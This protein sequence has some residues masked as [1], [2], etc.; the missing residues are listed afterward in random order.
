MF[1]FIYRW[2]KIYELNNDAKN[3]VMRTSLVH[4]L[5][6]FF[7]SFSN[8]YIFLQA[9]TVIGDVGKV[10]LL[11]SVFLFSEA[12]FALVAGTL[13]D[14][15]SFR[16]VLSLSVL[17]YFVTYRLV[18]VA[19]TFDQ[20]VL[21]YVLLGLSSAFNLEN[22]F[23]YFDNNYDYFV[24]EDTDR[25]IYSEFIGKFVAIKYLIMSLGVIVGAYISV[26]YSRE[27]L[28][29]YSS[30][31]L[32]LALILTFLFYK[33]HKNFKL[34]KKRRDKGFISVLGGSI[35][36][37]WSRR[38]LRF[39]I[40]GLVIAELTT[41]LWSEFYS[42]L[43]Y[44]NI[45]KTDAGVGLLYSA[46]I[47]IFAV[48]IG[49]LGIL[50]GR[51]KRVKFWY[52]FSML[53]AYTVFYF[54]LSYFLQKNPIPGNFGTNYIIIF[55]VIYLV[56][57]IPYNFNYI[58]Y[59]RTILDLMPE[60][61]R[62]SIYSLISSLKSILGAIILYI[63]SIYFTNN[64][65]AESFYY[66]GIIG[67]MG[68][69]IVFITLIRYN[70]KTTIKEPMGFFTAFLSNTKAGFGS[71]F[72]IQKS[73]NLENYQATIN[74]IVKE[75][76]AI[77]MSDMQ[78]TSEEKEMIDVIVTDIQAYFTMVSDFEQDKSTRKKEKKELLRKQKENIMKHAYSNLTK[79]QLNEDLTRLLVK[80]QDIMETI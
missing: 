80:L 34:S 6:V 46:E 74:N 9:V 49:F 35:K 63:A 8:I 52:L 68:S 67:L 11:L 60:T 38:T 51:V 3:F 41:V 39:F 40:I 50:V 24:Y 13:G 18:I 66:L 2:F 47:I 56:I 43:L 5:F 69:L 72:L 31:V 57:T 61:Y 17:F 64:N 48:S 14:S 25:S 30:F 36:Y 42:L 15:R 62:G 79:E 55:L 71:F 53:L 37:S 75:L 65:L 73:K 7:I 22:F 29:N 27:Q 21:V 19:Q 16:I 58:L 28:F 20:F 1:S 78:I 59:F 77:A 44:S 76:T 23:S 10:A 12:V 70:F 26:N 54:G 32:L 33:D 45:G 4:Y